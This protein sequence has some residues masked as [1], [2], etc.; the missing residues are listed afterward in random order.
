LIGPQIA[1]ADGEPNPKT[2]I[3]VGVAGINT[4]RL[5]PEDFHDHRLSQDAQTSSV[6]EY[7]P[8]SSEHHLITDSVYLT[9]FDSNAT[10]DKVLDLFKGSTGRCRADLG[11]IILGNSWG[12][13]NSYLLAK[14]Y[15]DFCGRKA[16]LLIMIDGIAKWVPTAFTDTFSAER[17]INYFQHESALAGNKIPGCEN[18][19]KTETPQF[20]LFESHLMIEW[21][22]IFNA[23]QKDI[24][25][26]L[27]AAGS[28]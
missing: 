10:L 4:V 15:T 19:K 8:T 21:D 13:T 24:R 6:W 28:R 2:F 27:D 26:Y 17:C 1:P 23:T 11:I 5:H 3:T 12:A 20:S 25:D 7:L 18:H 22:A 9:H 14:K 16:E